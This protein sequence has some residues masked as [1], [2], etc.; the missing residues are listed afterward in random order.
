MSVLH[1]VYYLH[2][3]L[4]LFSF[5]RTLKLNNNMKYFLD[6]LTV[7]CN[8]NKKKITKYL[9]YLNVREKIKALFY[10][11][12]KQCILFTNWQLLYSKLWLKTLDLVTI[13]LGFWRI[14][15]RRSLMLFLQ[16]KSMVCF[17]NSAEL[18]GQCREKVCKQR[19]KT[20]STRSLVSLN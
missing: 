17:N 10:A 7:R 19:V 12:M 8:D 5:T 20:Q 2:F 9:Q 6:F 13:S 4:I 3:F 16:K 14:R 1:T 15:K 11:K 18:K